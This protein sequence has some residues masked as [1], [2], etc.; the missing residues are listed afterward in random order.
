[1][2]L[3]EIRAKRNITFTELSK[4]KQFKGFTPTQLKDAISNDKQQRRIE[5]NRTVGYVDRSGGCM[6]YKAA[7]RRRRLAKETEYLGLEAPCATPK[8]G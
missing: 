7:D 8:L 4:A 1:M 2:L 6:K 3:L 5:F